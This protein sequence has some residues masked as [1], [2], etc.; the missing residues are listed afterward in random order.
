MKGIFPEFENENAERS[1]PFAGGRMRPEESSVDSVPQDVFVDA[2]LYPINSSGRLYL[3]RI[4]EHGCVFVSDDT[5][6]IMSGVGNG[7]VVELYETKSLGR[8][9]GTIA[10]SSA[11]ALSGFL[12]RGVE[13]KYSSDDTSFASS[14]VLPIVVDGVS[15]LSVGGSSPTCGMVNFL[16]GPYDSVRVSSGTKNGKSTL[17]FDVVP[18]DDIGM[19][20]SIRRII[21]VVDG[22]TPFRI[23][24]LSYNT[25]MLW[26]DSIGKEEVCAAAHREGSFEMSDTCSCGDDG[27]SPCEKVTTRGKDI[28]MFYHLEEVF[29][30]PDPEGVHGGIYDGSENAFYLI[31]PNVSGYSNPI[32]I[33]LEEGATTPKT[34]GPEVVEN[35]GMPEFA[36]GA[37]V[38]SVSSNGVVVQVPGLSGGQ[39]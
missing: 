37:F 7:K 3:S 38:D 26:L 27:K 9:C 2:I 5:G 25:V 36:E 4:S 24:K 35:D 16:N 31:V 12:G 32:S 13:R 22:Q 23:E 34:E 21:C 10:A 39:I 17:R 11:D 6:E 29:I 19:G 8:H 1:Y 18:S 20:D 33:T 28:P 15:S 14:C 30:P